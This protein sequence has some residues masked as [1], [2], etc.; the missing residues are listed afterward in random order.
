[1]MRNL[2]LLL[3]LSSLVAVFIPV[4]LPAHA[5]EIVRNYPMGEADDAEIGDEAIF[6]IDTVEFEADG[7][8]ITVDLLGFGTYVEGRNENSPLAISFNGLD[9]YFQAPAF[10]PRNFNSFATLSQGWIKPNSEGLG[11]EQTVWA[12]GNDNGGVTI[13]EDGFWQLNSGGPAGS[14]V[15]DTAVAFDEWS[16]LAVFRGGNS[17]TLYLNGSVIVTNDG[18]WNAPGEF[19]LGNGLSEETPFMGVIDD[20][21]ISGFGDGVFD[22]I[23]DIKFLDPDSLSGILGDVDPSQD[24]IVN[25]ADYM[26]WSNNVGFDNGLGVGDFSTLFRGDADQNGRVNFFDLE[27]IRNEAAAGGVAITVP[28]PSSLW[29]LALCS[30]G[31]LPFRRRARHFGRTMKS[32]TPAILSVITLVLLQGS[33]ET[34]NAQG[35]ILAEDFFYAQP[36]KTFGAGGGFTRQDYGGGQHS[37]LGQWQGRWNSF[38]DGIIVGSDVSEEDFNVELDLHQGATRNGLSSNWLDRDFTLTGMVDEPLFFGITIRSN[39]ETAMPNAT[40]SINDAGGASQISMGLTEGG[41]Q[42]ILGLPD[43]GGAADVIPEITMG[44]DAHRLIGKLELNASGN[45][46]RLTVWLDPTDVETAEN[47]VEVESNVIDGYGDFAG[48]LRLDHRDSGGLIFW[49]DLAVGTTWESVATVDVP[50]VSLL[51]DTETREFRFRNDTGSDLDVVFLQAASERG[52]RDAA[53][54]S[55]TDRGVPGF[56]ENNPTTNLLTESSFE[57]SF[58]FAAGASETW[59][60]LLRSKTTTDFIGRVGTSDGLL[61]VTNVIYGEIPVE[62]DIFSLCDAIAAGSTDTSFDVNG[63]G[64]VDGADLTQFQETAGILP[65]DLNLDGEVNFTDFLGLSG[66][67]G[68]TDSPGWAAGDLDCNGAVEFGDFLVLSANF[69]RTS[70]TTALAANVPE[71]SG[72]LLSVIGLV[73][74]MTSL[75]SRQRQLAIIV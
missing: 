9:E 11:L 52:M 26:V 19:Y 70:M 22:Q 31:V 74:L 48:N 38:G 72:S 42:A 61:N 37:E 39:N 32:V 1:M 66:A 12:V 17:G 75:R 65:G 47:T 57:T 64:V 23:R 24:G 13:T 14:T 71:T 2:S 43:E 62:L 60:E 40:F 34:A 20:F 6:T 69:G 54:N 63:D 33:L 7:G 46:E 4:S 29:G 44:L 50:R 28:E 8:G 16:H 21:A 55:L 53:W 30:L 45:S 10:D 5:A 41:F 58:T 59:G 67:F 51:V 27:I 18:F 25:Q 3:T 35:V 68:Q 36:T 15:S 56:A 49:D 73:T